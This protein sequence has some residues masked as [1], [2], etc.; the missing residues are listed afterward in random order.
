MDTQM[1]VA[2]V[3]GSLGTV[4]AALVHRLVEHGVKT[5][6]VVY[7][8]AAYK[9]IVDARATVIP[10][11]MRQVNELPEKISEK[12]DAFFHLAWMGTIGPNRDNVTLQLENV[13]CAIA[14][15]EAAQALG[16]QVF[17]GTGSQAECGRIEGLVKPDSPC[18]PT[19][20]YGIA[21][22]CAGQ[23]TRMACKQKGLRH[24]WGRIL[25][26]YGPHDGPL[27][28]FPSMMEKLL[29]GEK[30][31]LTAGEQMWDF[32]FSEDVAEALYCMACRGKDGA[33]YPIG[34]GQARPLKEY[35]FILRDAIDPTL[36]LGIG[37][38][39]YAPNQVMHLQADI[40]P[41]VN[42]TGF[43]PQHSF[44]EGIRITLEHYKRTQEI[45]R[46]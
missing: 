9:D 14:A 22:L 38:R 26:A 17:V 45:I 7:P 20:G 33:I 32:L 39:P 13:Q 43:A 12:V 34:S 6:A 15:V 46:Q 42:D 30:P 24:V 5:Y 4:G 41:L 25:S 16:C 23:M 37:E 29:K 36:P 35:F 3:N 1:K 18:N 44:E 27:S 21:K 11:D 40:Q 8:G 2:V 19:T 28:L 10:C 31:A